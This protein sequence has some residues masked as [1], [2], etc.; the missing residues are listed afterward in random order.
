MPRFVLLYHDCPATYPR[1]SHWDLMLEEGNA[2]RTWA[3]P[4][5]PRQWRRAYEQ[6][7]GAYPNAPAIAE[8]DEVAAERLGDH[9]LD[10]LEFEGDISSNRGRVARVAS[11]SY[12]R[13]DNSA[14]CIKFVLSGDLAISHVE[15]RR[16][17]AND[18]QW[19]LACK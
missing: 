6:T 19:W 16:S 17:S 12:H 5:L 10:Y 7:A 15:L 3:L 9:R 13:E 18:T 14:D 8:A 4:T 11:G 2:L 1:S